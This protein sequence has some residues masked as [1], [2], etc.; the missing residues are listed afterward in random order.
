M[1]NADRR[2]RLW[3]LVAEHAHGRQ[4]AVE[5]VCAAVRSA[6]GVDR[7][8]V[9]V[10]L[11][12]TPWETLYASDQIALEL[13]E[14]AMTVGEGPG[15]DPLANGPTLVADLTA[16]E[17]LARWPMFAPAAV[18]AGV[19]AVFAFPLQV[20]AVRLGVMDLYHGTPGELQRRRLA[21]ALLLA[22]TACALLL[23][24]ARPGGSEVAG[25]WPARAGTEHPEVHQ[26]TGMITVQLGVTAA[27]ALIR[28]RAYAYAHDRRLHDVAG[29]VVARRLR[30][31]PEPEGAADERGG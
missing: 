31:D 15:L 19:R 14:L 9:A 16:A 28:L 17:C 5:D 23:D 27:V 1:M 12:A 24:A 30:F 20:G 22:D 11:A 13:R 25:R 10:Q 3:R 26:A 8:A 2:M 4:V 6:V 29:D 18:D 7:I 21:D